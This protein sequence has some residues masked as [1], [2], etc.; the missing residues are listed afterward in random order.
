M[1]TPSPYRQVLP[2]GLFYCVSAVVMCMLCLALQDYFFEQRAYFDLALQRESKTPYHWPMNT[3]GDIH[4]E[5][6]NGIEN[7]QVGQGVVRFVAGEDDTYLSLNLRGRTIDA[8][9]YSQ[10]S[11]RIHSSEAT[12]L[13]VVHY[14]T[15]DGFNAHGTKNLFPLIAGWQVLNVDMVSEPL[16]L[17]V[18]RRH[19][20][21]GDHQLRWGGADQ[22]VTGLRLDPTQKRGTR[23][24]L[25]WVKLEPVSSG[26]SAT[27]PGP[28]IGEP[29]VM[30]ML[31]GSWPEQLGRL[32]ASPLPR[33]V[34]DDTAWRLPPSSAWLRAEVLRLQPRA[35]FFPRPVTLN[36]S[37]DSHHHLDAHNPFAPYRTLLCTAALLTLLVLIVVYIRAKDRAPR[38]EARLL[39]VAVLVLSVF[40]WLLTTVESTPAFAILAIGLLLAVIC[41]V[42]SGTGT[43]RENSG[44]RLGSAN[45][46]RDTALYSTPP[47]ILII[48][49][50]FVAPGIEFDSL[51]LAR[52]LFA[53]P[54][55]GLIQQLIL[56]PVLA[57]LI[58]RS[59]G[60]IQGANTSR[61][62]LLAALSAGAIFALVHAPNFALMITTLWMGP[63]WAYIYL[64][65]RTILPQALAHG[66]SGALFQVLAPHS[67][68]INGTVGIEHFSW[69]W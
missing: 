13:Q 35:I 8:S 15:G 56:G 18:D 48:T 68:R 49:I 45:A 19:P 44:V 24:Q 58:V 63:I 37:V 43:W 42:A 29:M 66:V 25:D 22:R 40:L 38:F 16:L 27:R 14:L 2:I 46:W 51:V 10:L 32:K 30:D 17:S 26:S 61:H 28:E 52:S 69:M 20:P 60:N 55:W 4:R 11:F 65:Y 57:A 1:A 59:L 47:I 31:S 5:T 41:A 3:L 67:L 39:L 7:L 9:I 50:Y 34:I 62:Q 33:V 23:I 54:F 12:Q 21:A 36:S 53:Y 64:T 6:R